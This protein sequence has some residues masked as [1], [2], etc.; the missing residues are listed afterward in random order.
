MH[1]FI[2]LSRPHSN[3]HKPWVELD[4]NLHDPSSF[5]SCD[6]SE[7]TILKYSELDSVEIL[8]SI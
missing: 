1:V 2:T 4:I 3:W 8:F 5:S 6:I 7:C